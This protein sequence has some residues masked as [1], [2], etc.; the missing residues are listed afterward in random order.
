MKKILIYS[1]CAGNIIKVMFEHH[2]IT[3]NE[4]TVSYL[5]NYVNLH[6]TNLDLEHE[7]LL[8]ECDIF[9][10][11]P[12]NQ[13]YNFTEYDIST[14]LTYLKEQ[15]K[16]NCCHKMMIYTN[17]T[18]PK[19]WSRNIINYFEKKINYKLIDQIILAFK[20]NGKRVEICRTTHNKTHKDLIKCTKIPNDAEIC[21][22]DDFFYP[23]MTHD[24]IYYIN[25]KP[26]YH[27]LEFNEMLLR[28]KNSKIGKKIID[29]ENDFD[30]LM[31]EHI[32]LFR[33]DVVKKSESEYDIDK[34][35]GK[36]IISHLQL[37][38]NN[39]KKNKT[40]KNRF[41]K[42]NKTYKNKLN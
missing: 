27:D 22:I 28:F 30:I 41:N 33:Y 5:W 34:I 24:N 31:N 12:F 17:N 23:E 29:D 16:L 20:I 15:K 8:R 10:Y 11:Q 35:L 42:K 18:G 21:F 2:N 19:E 14:I 1:N 3:K 25:I 7:I 4:F 36:H 38:F 39:S 13:N 40:I 32:N 9:I 37:F 6:K 26:Y